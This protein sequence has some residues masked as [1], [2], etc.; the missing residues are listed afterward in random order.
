MWW[1]PSLCQL[2]GQKPV[3]MQETRQTSSCARTLTPV[4]R[5]ADQKMYAGGTI[6]TQGMA[7]GYPV[8]M[9]AHRHS[10]RS[11]RSRSSP[12]LSTLS[13]RCQLERLRSDASVSSQRATSSR[14]RSRAVAIL[15]VRAW[16]LRKR[17]KISVFMPTNTISWSTPSSSLDSTHKFSSPSGTSTGSRLSLLAH[18]LIMRNT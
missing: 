16:S 17:C 5:W 1:T 2:R 3:L 11:I 14:W 4:R 6:L 12:L 15:Q 9:W 13:A 8:S 18:F 7:A 10:I